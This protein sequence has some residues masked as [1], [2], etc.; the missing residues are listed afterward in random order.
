MKKKC[1]KNR[2]GEKKVTNIFPRTKAGGGREDAEM[3]EVAEAAEQLTDAHSSSFK[4]LNSS[5]KAKKSH[6]EVRFV[7]TENFK[8]ST[9]LQVLV[10]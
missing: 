6:P 5:R 10:N 7:K 3:A 8:S 2:R 1:E 9:F 4:R